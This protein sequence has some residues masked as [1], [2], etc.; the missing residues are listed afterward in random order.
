MNQ[1]LGVAEKC[2]TYLG[3]LCPWEGFQE[4]GQWYTAWA[5]SSRWKGWSQGSTTPSAPP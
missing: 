1:H 3:P 2:V 4:S 5:G